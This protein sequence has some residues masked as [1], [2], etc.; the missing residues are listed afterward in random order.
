MSPNDNSGC[1]SPELVVSFCGLL[2][3]RLHCGHAGV[4]IQPSGSTSSVHRV[5]TSYV[6]S[7]AW[8]GRDIE[9]ANQEHPVHWWNKPST[10]G[11]LHHV[12]R[13]AAGT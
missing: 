2:K 9:P 7:Q 10:S 1:L 11:R 3:A 8:W 12:P 6:L 5:L 13:E 4:I